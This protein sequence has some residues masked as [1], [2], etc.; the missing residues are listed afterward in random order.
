LRASLIGIDGSPTRYFHAGAGF[1]VLLLH[2]VGMAA[3]SWVRNVPALAERYSVV[4]PDLLGSG[5]TG[6]GPA[7]PEAPQLAIVRHL[8]ALI[9]RLAIGRFAVVGSSLGGLIAT[10]L[11]FA[12]PD[13][14]RALAVAGSAALL[15]AS[16]AELRTVFEASYRNGIRAFTD[17]SLATNRQRLANIVV[18][19]ARVP[20]SVLV[21]Q[22][23]AYAL[24]GARE[25]YERRLRGLIA[26]L[27]GDPAAWVSHRLSDIRVP[28]LAIAGRED[29][30]TN[31]TWEAA[32]MKQVPNGR[33]V[34]I[35]DC[36]HFPHLE[37]PETFLRL[38]FDFIGA[39]A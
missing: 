23:C 34:T 4:A 2:G 21:M 14:V 6:A 20:E 26:S 30:R 10:L 27:D 18:D 35:E 1:P 37:H 33:S 11:Y 7:G 17:N 13:R 28:M 5:F 22:L 38:L 3:D 32:A 29:P 12:M 24:P 9:D 25:A 36:G 31:P 39:P 15:A 16:P 19:P 8:A